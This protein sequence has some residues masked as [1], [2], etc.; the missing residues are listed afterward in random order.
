ME[1]TVLEDKKP[2]GCGCGTLIEAF[3]KWRHRPRNFVH[4]HTNRG[5]RFPQPGI[6]NRVC[7]KCGGQ[8]RLDKRGNPVW[9]FDGDVLLCSNCFDHLRI[10]R[11]PEGQ[12]KRWL[13]YYYRNKD[14]CIE[15][16]KKYYVEN[17]EVLIKNRVQRY[18]DHK[19]EENAVVRK[20]RRKN[21]TITKRRRVA[22][23]I[24]LGG[25]CV[26]CGYSKDF[27]AL[28][29]DHINGFGFRDRKRFAS[30]SIY[31]RHYLDNPEE[32]K[33]NLQVLCCNCNIIKMTENNEYR[34]GY[35]APTVTMD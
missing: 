35:M 3:D 22:I 10:E 13:D 16:T 32:A 11:D 7:S 29:L 20:S 30:V 12:K 27:R 6:R 25:K 2:C 33:K 26:T 31:Y 14:I 34:C 19:L 17:K 4:G 8:T 23:I 1:E 9:R 5:K 15:K 28:C 18:R 24:S 21:G